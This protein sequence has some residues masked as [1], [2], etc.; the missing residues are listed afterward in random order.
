[1]AFGINILEAE[2]SQPPSPAERLE[3]LKQKW[4][5]WHLEQANA[6]R[7]QK[8]WF[9]SAFHLSRLIEAN[10]ASA[11]FL[12]SRG[13]AYAEMGDWDRAGADFARARTVAASSVSPLSP[14]LDGI[15][16]LYC[17]QKGDRDG[18]RRVCK[19]MLARWS[20]APTPEVA[21][22]MLRCAVLTPDATKDKAALLRLADRVRGGQIL[23]HKALTIRGAVLFRAGRF[24]EA[25][26]QL[27]EA[28]REEGKGGDGWECLFLAMTLHRLG[29]DAEA[30][31]W[32]QKGHRWVENTGRG[33]DWAARLDV[34]VLRREAETLLNLNLKEKKP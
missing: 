3:I 22:H 8:L 16:S 23:R 28:V 26:Q 32:L 29:K 11:F 25:A 6:R 13:N 12:G 30:K 10:P 34:T 4:L 24:E 7:D 20:Q 5:F 15:F 33:L 21:F 14:V 1:L 17:L 31:E 2:E 19:E 9:A 27:R 18:H